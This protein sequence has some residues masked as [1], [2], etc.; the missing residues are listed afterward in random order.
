MENILR[1][2]FAIPPQSD[3]R[4]QVVKAYGGH[5]VKEAVYHCQ[6]DYLCLT[7]IDN[8]ADKTG[9]V[10]R[11]VCIILI[12]PYLFSLATHF[13]LQE[14]RITKELDRFNQAMTDT[15]KF[16]SI[17]RLRQRHNL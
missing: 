6:A 11:Q 2:F 1:R 15:I 12:A 16:G 17:H 5:S 8:T 4:F 9:M 3:S 7:A 14:V 13:N 10:F